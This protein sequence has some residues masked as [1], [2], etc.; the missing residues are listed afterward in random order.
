MKIS[1]SGTPAFSTEEIRPTASWPAQFETHH[2]AQGA[3]TNA[4]ETIRIAIETNQKTSFVLSIRY[5]GE[6]LMPLR[7]LESL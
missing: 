7:V 5:S 6:V 3:S 1:V 4:I 2:R